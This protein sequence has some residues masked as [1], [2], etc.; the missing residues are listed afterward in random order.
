[1]LMSRKLQYS[2]QIYGHTYAVLIILLLWAFAGQCQDK[3][4]QYDETRGILF[5]NDDKNIKNEKIVKKPVVAPVPGKTSKQ[6]KPA[7][8]AQKPGPENIHA[9]R[10]KDPPDLYFKSGLQYFRNA[11][12]MNALKNFLYAHSA[13]PKPE[14]LLWAGKTYRNIEQYDRM[15]DAML[16]IKTNHPDCDVADD[17]IFELAQYY[18][19]I[20]DYDSAI[21]FY[22]ELAEQYPFGLSF[23]EGEEYLELSRNQR[24]VMRAEMV[25][26]LKV[27]GYDG[28]TVTDAIRSFQKKN[29]LPVTG[30][31]IRETVRAIKSQYER[32]D[33]DD[34]RRQEES[35]QIR[36]GSITAVA[37]L[38]VLSLNL[39]LI[40]ALK[41]K[42]RKRNIMLANMTNTLLELDVKKI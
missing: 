11:D 21:H 19:K 1:M 24:Q 15:K 40:L 17:A 33:K 31:P 9:G 25:S 38:A 8:S 20:D 29:G 2:Y 14:Y 41:S 39:W 7:T 32:K 28:N 37:A 34:T 30:K 4:I 18:Q 26:A 5:S 3:T 12:Y 36:H 22:T 6:V 35:V 23:L 16:D 13:E 10:Q 27:L 42:I